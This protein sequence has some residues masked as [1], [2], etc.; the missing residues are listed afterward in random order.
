M[1]KKTGRP[2]RGGLR[3]HRRGR[4]G[5][6]LG[7]VLC[8]AFFCS[9]HDFWANSLMIIHV[10]FGDRFNKYFLFYFFEGEG[11]A[12]TGGAGPG[13]NLGFLSSWK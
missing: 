9:R 12:L 5:P 13:P 11:F 7:Y 10:L 2:F 1:K 8:V 6:N 4:A 3:P